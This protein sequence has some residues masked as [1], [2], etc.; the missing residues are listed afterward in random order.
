M[1]SGSGRPAMAG[2]V[3]EGKWRRGGEENSHTG[4]IG[5]REAVAL[6]EVIP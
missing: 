3:L 5:L 6:V 2:S 4:F 1:A